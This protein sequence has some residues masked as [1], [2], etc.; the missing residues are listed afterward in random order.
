MGWRTAKRWTKA[1]LR[2]VVVVPLRRLRFRGITTAIVTGTNGKTTTTRML[3][4]ILEQSGHRVGFCS[5]EG[6]VIAGEVIR[7]DDC[8]S[9]GGAAAVLGDRRIT[10]AVLEVA[11]G[12][13][14][15]HGPYIDRCGAAALLNIGN[16]QVGMDGIDTLEQ[17][18]RLK[19]KAVDTGRTVVLNA[20]DALCLALVDDYPR[21]RVTLFSF[22]PAG[23][24]AREHLERGGALVSVADGA[25]GPTITW[26]RGDAAIPVV[27]I[28][29]LPSAMDGIVRHNVAN[30]MAAT[31]LAIGLGV[32]G[33][34]IAS[35][36]ASFE[37]TF[38]QSCGRFNLVAGYPFTVV[39]DYA[40]NPPAVAVA[41]RAIDQ[42]KIRGQRLCLL[43]GVG[44]R[45]DSAYDEIAA[46]A[47]SHFDRF[48]CFEVEH[49][50]RGR[51]VG[52]IAQRLAAGLGARGVAPD[53]I[54]LACELESALVHAC[55]RVRPGDLV[56]VLGEDARAALPVLRA[57]F[58]RHARPV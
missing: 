18:A 57:V 33:A 43:S 37:N 14:L 4:H 16:E 41:V 46:A 10:A 23:R 56:A 34:V 29:E 5:T 28:S 40:S 9:Y 32:D 31:A 50:R 2:R 35:A 51:P 54:D 8:G 22:D 30:A 6:I 58:A 52:E 44:N 26:R 53:R 1:R 48:V 45:P 24:P 42:L 55:Y 17:M 3:A 7:G 20:D 27:A 47:A 15:S 13:L 39:M 25:K 21:P 36:L 11:R 49:Y 38:E 12:G 19:Q